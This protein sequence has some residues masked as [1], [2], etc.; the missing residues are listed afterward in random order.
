MV[1]GLDYFEVFLWVM[2]GL[3]VIPIIYASIKP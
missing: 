3:S 2:A 1:D